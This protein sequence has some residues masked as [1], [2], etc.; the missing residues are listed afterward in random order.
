MLI[1]FFT[2]LPAF[3]SGMRRSPRTFNLGRQALGI[4]RVAPSSLCN[5]LSIGTQALSTRAVG[6]KRA[7]SN[8]VGEVPLDAK[9]GRALDKK[10][11]KKKEELAELE[12]KSF[13]LKMHVALMSLFS[14]SCF[15]YEFFI[16]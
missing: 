14:A 12:G 16:R 1:S 3:S 6:A 2:L 9:T 11:Q 5:R 10:W 15:I 4:N 7:Y 8:Q 13:A